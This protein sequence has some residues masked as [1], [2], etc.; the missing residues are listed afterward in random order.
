MTMEK[1]VEVD[2]HSQMKLEM[3]PMML[4]AFE[5][6]QWMKRQKRLVLVQGVP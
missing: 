6:N 4:L 3:E 5:T 2:T 1:F